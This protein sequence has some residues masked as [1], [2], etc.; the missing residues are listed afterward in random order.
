MRIDHDE[1]T[2][3]IV[4]G[5]GTPKKSIRMAKV[6]SLAIIDLFTFA[7]KKLEKLNLHETRFAAKQR[8]D[9]EQ[10]ISAV[11]VLETITGI[12]GCD[13]SDLT[14]EGFTNFGF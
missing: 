6:N 13:E 4:V 10:K 14:K 12:P 1:R 7:R 11:E 8:K 5:K 2:M 9:R 3:D